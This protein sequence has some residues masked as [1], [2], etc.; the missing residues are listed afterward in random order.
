MNYFLS[1]LIVQTSTS[2]LDF[3][4][5]LNCVQHSKTLTHANQTSHTNIYYII[6]FFKFPNKITPD[7]G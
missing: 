5:N 4:C 1:T 6:N 3:K 7:G 2:H